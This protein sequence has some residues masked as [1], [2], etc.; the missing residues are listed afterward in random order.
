MTLRHVEVFGSTPNGGNDF[1]IFGDHGSTSSVAIGLGMRVG[2]RK[3]LFVDPACGRITGLTISW[4]GVD[5]A[6]HNPW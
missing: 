1:C 4:G 6:L 3:H 2:T 5:R